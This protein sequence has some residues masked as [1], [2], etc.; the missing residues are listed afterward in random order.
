M[1][2][3]IDVKLENTIEASHKYEQRDR[4]NRQLGIMVLNRSQAAAR[5]RF[6]VIETGQHHFGNRREFRHNVLEPL[7]FIPIGP[8]IEGSTASW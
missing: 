5:R 7:S 1:G 6:D 3:P 4:C 8:D 2:E